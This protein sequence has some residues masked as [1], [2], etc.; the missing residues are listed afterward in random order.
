MDKR[1]ARRSFAS[2]LV[3][4]KNPDGSHPLQGEMLDISESGLL[5]QLDPAAKIHWPL[6]TLLK[7]SCALPTG[8]FYAQAEIT[9]LDTKTSRAGLRWLE[10]QSPRDHKNLLALVTNGFM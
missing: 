9:R 10:F 4:L 5:I 8:P 2:T 6:G 1:I 7:V 3:Q